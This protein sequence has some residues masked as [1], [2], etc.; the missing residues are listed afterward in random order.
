MT[1]SAMSRLSGLMVAVWL[2]AGPALAEGIFFVQ[3][4]SLKSEERARKAWSEL[5]AKHAELLGDLALTVQ[6]T[7]VA[8]RGT[9]YRLQ[10]GP[11]P[12]R[13]T[14]EDMCQQLRTAKLDCLV[15]QR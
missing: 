11:F 13:A 1:R 8:G 5:Q 9:F 6:S 2:A 4:A 15:R 12:N 10:T 3:L 7:E 14:A